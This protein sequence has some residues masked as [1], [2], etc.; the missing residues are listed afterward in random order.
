[1]AYSDNR[2]EMMEALCKTCHDQEH[3]AEVVAND[4]AR[5]R[6]ARNE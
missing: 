2:P 4:K 6:A 5:A 3:H 1:M